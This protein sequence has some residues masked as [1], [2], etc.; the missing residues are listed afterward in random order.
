MR[1]GHALAREL[2]RLE[3]PTVT[4]DRPPRT[5][6]PPA[7]PTNAEAKQAADTAEIQRLSRELAHL[8]RRDVAVDG[9]LAP[10]Q[11]ARLRADGA[12]FRGMQDPPRRFIEL[13]EYR[14]L[15][16]APDVARRVL[17]R[18]GNQT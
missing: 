3:M 11:F 10:G 7:P 17:E 12:V 16:L 2:A 13:A 18:D 1:R 5:R 15:N 14:A 6:Q 9:R 4:G 8:Y